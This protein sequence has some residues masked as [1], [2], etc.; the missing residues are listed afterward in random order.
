MLLLVIVAIVAEALLASTFPSA[1]V[2][3]Y[4]GTSQPAEKFDFKSLEGRWFRPD[5]GYLLD[6]KDIRKDGSLKA[7][8]FNPRSINVAK[9]QLRRKGGRITLLVE[10]RDINYPGST[11]TLQYDP[12][13]DLLIGTYFQSVERQTYEVEFQRIR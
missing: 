12:K 6:L 7:A 10:L 3:A 4:A 9:A 5:G 2:A 11:Y 13:E 8:Y 1:P